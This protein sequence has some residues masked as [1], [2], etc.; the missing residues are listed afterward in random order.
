MA[1]PI[2][3]LRHTAFPNMQEPQGMASSRGGQPVARK[4][5]TAFLHG[6]DILSHGRLTKF[7]FQVLLQLVDLLRELA[8]HRAQ[9]GDL[10]VLLCH[11]HLHLVEAIIGLLEEFLKAFEL[12]HFEV[13]LVRILVPYERA[14]EQVAESQAGITVHSQ[15]GRETKTRTKT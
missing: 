13:G 14:P 12:A 10:L 8:K 6:P 15:L 9:E 4:A 1:K 3:Q 7:Q 2:H 5:H 11:G